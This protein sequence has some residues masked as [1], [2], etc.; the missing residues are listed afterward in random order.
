MKKFFIITGTSKGIGKQLAAHY[1]SQGHKVSGCSRGKSRIKHSNYDHYELNVCEEKS[2][3]S[4]I[5]SIK[6]KHK[7]VDVLLNNAGIGGM[8]HILTTP[9]ESVKKIFETNFFGTFLFSREVGKIMIKQKTGKIVNYTSVAV[10]LKL[11]GEAIYAASKS[12][13]ESFTRISAKEL[14]KF[15]VCINAIGPNP[16]PTDLIKNIKKEKID[17]LLNQQAIPR[18]G[19]FEDILN[20]INFFIDKK[21]EFVTGQVIYLAGII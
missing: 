1:L 11:E 3:I 5:K 4:M 12:A 7:R 20:V 8:N 14:G 9:Y 6:K 10:P 17:T 15:G 2:V 18:L 19:K 13:I 21:S 16:I